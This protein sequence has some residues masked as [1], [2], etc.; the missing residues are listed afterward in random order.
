MSKHEV[1][2]SARDPRRA[3]AALPVPIWILSFEANAMRWANVAARRFWGRP[4]LKAFREIDLSDTRPATREAFARRVAGLGPGETVSYVMTLMPLGRPRTVQV[5]NWAVEFEGEPCYAFMACEA[6][7]QD[8]ELRRS[9]RLL[10]AAARSARRLLGGSDWEIETPALLD[11]LRRTAEVD[12]AYFFRRRDEESGWSE[13]GRIL[14]DQLFER[15][16][17]A[18]TPQIDNPMLQG[19]D[20]VEVGLERWLRRFLAGEPVAAADVEQ[21]PPHEL[22]MLLAQDIA[23]ICIQPVMSGDRL[24]G[25]IGCD[26]CGAPGEGRAWPSPVVDALEAG[27]HLLGAA[28]AN[29][30]TQEALREALRGCE[31]GAR[32]KAQ[33]LATMS[34]ELRTPLNGVVGLGAVLAE[35]PLARNDAALVEEMRRS[36]AEMVRI[37]DDI[38]DLVDMESGGVELADEPFDPDALARQALAALEPVSREK[39]IGLGF[40][41]TGAPG[42]RRGDAVRLGQALRALL[43]NAVKF[44]E[45]GAVTVELSTERDRIAFI[46][47]DTGV[48][49]TE[50]QA[51]RMFDPFVQ[52]DSSATRRH[53][54]SGL[55]LALARRLIERMGGS[56]SL[57]SRPGRGT[58]ARIRVPLPELGRG[59]DALTTAESPAGG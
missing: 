22:P 32:A 15:C 2:E 16:A 47:R 6:P 3:Y 46:V 56:I 33:F 17:A 8:E 10:S 19:L 28:I 36:G 54:G 34:H 51:A 24:L 13:D 55:G 26:V 29:A 1:I 31:A 14:F 49:M 41:R 52:A 57:E 4:S 23:A 9:D 7:I 53:G 5:T 25:L 39:G 11:V 27:A 45:T 44:T 37:V 40:R 42:L 20:L 18:A 50:E 21:L 30:R 59:G 48:G 35:R 58:A 38:L 12:R 43:D